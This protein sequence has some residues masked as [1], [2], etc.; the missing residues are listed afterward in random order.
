MQTSQKSH[1]TTQK[2]R[3]NKITES[4]KEQKIE[5]D[6]QKKSLKVLNKIIPPEITWKNPVES[7]KD[8]GNR[9]RKRQRI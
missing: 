1:K 6:T 8:E 4:F 7:L 5:N 2:N 3:M 9:C